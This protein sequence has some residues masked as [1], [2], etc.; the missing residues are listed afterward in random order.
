MTSIEIPQSGDGRQYVKGI[1]D[2]G[3]LDFQQ[4]GIEEISFKG[5]FGALA[6]SDTSNDLTIGI[7][8]FY[9]DKAVDFRVGDD[10]QITCLSN[11]DLFMW[12]EVIGVADTDTESEMSIEVF[13]DDICNFSDTGVTNWEIQVVA[14]PKPGIEKDTSTTSVNP[15][16]GGPWTFTVTAGKFFP[17]GGTL[18]IKPTADRTIALIGEVEAYSGTSLTVTLRSTN[19]TVSQ[20]YTSWSIALLDSPPADLP[21]LAV[22]GLV[23][24]R[25]SS[26][27]HSITVNPGSIM[28]STGEVLLTLGSALSKTTTSLWAVGDTNGGVQQVTLAGTITA[29]TTAVTGSGTA[30]TTDFVTASSLTDFTAQGSASSFAANIGLTGSAAADGIRTLTNA[31]SLDTNV[32]IGGT[33]VAYGRNGRVGTTGASL[34]YFVVLIRK[35]TDGSLDVCFSSATPSGEPDLPSGYT[36]YRVLAAVTVGVGATASASTYTF[37]QPLYTSSPFYAPKDKRFVITGG[38]TPNLPEAMV[39]GASTTNTITTG[40]NSVSIERTALTGDVAASANSNTTTAQPAMIT[41]KTAKTTPVNADVLLIADSAASFALKKTTVSELGAV[42]GGSGSG[43]GA[44]FAD[45]GLITDTPTSTVDYGT[46]V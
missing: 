38:T 10:V 45:Y 44:N 35:D 11:Y 19:A 46:I 22:T 12:G 1:E 24:E 25:T 41:G 14:R 4:I 40:T 18:L 29:T 36:Y 30:F 15:T 7:K 16:T 20:A 27:T 13:V 39:L 42:I 2:D 6:R 23:V 5:R 9:L 8:T 28:D 17:I 3:T 43:V 32:A 37:E 21:L 31:T 34:V 33:A 26:S